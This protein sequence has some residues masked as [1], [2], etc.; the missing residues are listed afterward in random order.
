MAQSS[1]GRTEQSQPITPAF[2][3]RARQIMRFVVLTA[4]VVFAVT[5]AVLLAE[6]S[7]ESARQ[8]ARLCAVALRSTPPGGMA[9]DIRQLISQYGRL[10]GAARLGTGGAAVAVYPESPSVRR[11]VAATIKA[12]GDLVRTRIEQ[13]GVE[14]RAWGVRQ[15]IDGD[16]STAGRRMVF[17]FHRDSFLLSW[18]AATGVFGLFVGT[19]VHFGVRAITLWFDQRVADPLRNLSMFKTGDVPHEDRSGGF[20]SGGWSETE[21]IAR[22]LRVLDQEVAARQQQQCRNEQRRQCFSAIQSK[23]KTLRWRTFGQLETDP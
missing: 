15:A 21:A 16:D 18:L 5:S 22:Q 20:R 12:P 11:A 2:L 13:R 9:D 6:S 10:V 19:T 7:K 3:R 1:T 17:L 8:Q 4:V 14:Q 23:R